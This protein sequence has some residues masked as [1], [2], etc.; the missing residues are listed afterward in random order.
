MARMSFIDGIAHAEL[1]NRSML[2]VGL[3]P[4]PARFPGAVVHPRT[5][6]NPN[7]AGDRAE[8]FDT[9]HHCAAVVQPRRH[10]RSFD[11]SY[12]AGP[13]FRDRHSRNNSP[14]SRGD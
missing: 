2:C 9:L 11:Y 14:V 7:H 10:T 5:G 8:Y 3:D 6:A 13:G 4:D 12:R 1:L